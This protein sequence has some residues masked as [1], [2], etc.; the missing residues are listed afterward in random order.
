MKLVV[1]SHRPKPR[2][3]HLRKPCAKC[4]TRHY[5]LTAWERC[6]ARLLWETPESRTISAEDDS[7]DDQ[8]G[9]C[10]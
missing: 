1:P 5:T 8:G 2:A 4:G 9:A 7:G 10:S 3:P 6:R